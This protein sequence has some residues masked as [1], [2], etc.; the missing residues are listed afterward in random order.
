MA[1]FPSIVG[2]QSFQGSFRRTCVI[3]ELHNAHILDR[4]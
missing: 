1:A 3:G 2:V 4:V